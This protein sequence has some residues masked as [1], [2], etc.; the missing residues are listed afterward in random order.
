VRAPLLAALAAAIFSASPALADTL[1]DNINGMSVARDGTVTRFT[2]MVIGKDGKIVQLLKRGDTRPRVDYRVDEKGRAVIP[3]MIDSD[4]HLMDLGFA[5]LTLDLSDAHSLA[6]A[7]AKIAEYAKKF[8]DRPWIVGRGWNREAWG[9]GRYPTAADLDTMVPDRPVWLTSADGHAGWANSKALTMAGVTTATPDPQGGRIERLPGGR[10][11]AGVLVDNAMALVDAKLP[12]P[13]PEDRDLAF[14]KAQGMLIKD[15]VTA[16]GDMGTTIQDWQ[17]YRRAGDTGK[18]M[19]R[20]MAYA[21]TV[22]DLVLIGGP[23]PTPWLYDDRL[24][25]NGLHLSLDGALGSSGAWLKAPYTDD[26]KSTGIRRMD[27]TQLRN[28]M[29]RAALDNFQVAVHAVGDAANAEVLSA[30]EEMSDTYKGDRRWRIEQAAVVDPADIPRFGKDAVVASM[31][32]AQVASERT[33]AEARLGP[34]RL[35]GAFAWHSIEATGADLAFGSGAPG[36]EPSPF[37][38]IATAITREDANGQ[39]FG[40]WQPQEIVPREEA[41]AAYTAGAAYAGF[42]DGRFGELKPGERADFLVVDKDPMLASTQELREMKPAEVWINGRQVS[43]PPAHFLLGS[44]ET[45]R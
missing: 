10:A 42:A 32:P 7:Q 1:I 22:D 45:G 34:D 38:G 28:L 43:G 23:G 37:T 2:G 6:D 24:R 26:P 36:E 9:L 13:R 5:A 17:T 25:L 4:V 21:P 33:T 20:I 16:V 15:G 19:I 29:S 40:G 14:A 41:F 18:L 44:E 3:G 30:I 31:Q 12:E 27:S 11:P 39:P 8:P 35:A